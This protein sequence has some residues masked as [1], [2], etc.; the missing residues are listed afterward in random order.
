[1]LSTFLISRLGI[2]YVPEGRN[3]FPNLTVLENL[4]IAYRNIKENSWNIK[5]VLDL[6]P[7]LNEK[8]NRG[9]Q[10]LS[11][12]EQQMLAIGRA[13]LSD[14]DLLI[15]DEATEGLAPII[16]QEIWKVLKEICST[17]ITTIIVDKNIPSI[18][19]IAD[20]VIVLFKGRVVVD[21]EPSLFLED[22]EKKNMYLGV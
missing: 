4:K 10:E 3:I 7:R 16:S 14:P 5:R 6:F 21:G 22:P 1:M 17:G 8:L 12:G 18:L 13:L 2:G 11:G 9:G 20:Q 19:D 15:L